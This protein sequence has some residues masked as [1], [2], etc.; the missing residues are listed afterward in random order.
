[1]RKQ[2]L[3]HAL[4]M[5][6]IT[7]SW[8]LT[9]IDLAS[10]VSAKSRELA[11]ALSVWSIAYLLGFLAGQTIA[12]SPGRWRIPYFASAILILAI[13]P[14]GR[15]GAGPLLGLVLASVAMGL[16]SAASTR[17]LFDTVP[18]EAWSR[19]LA[20]VKLVGGTV[21]A[22]A[23]AV[24]VI[25][26]HTGLLGD[27][28]AVYTASAAAVIAAGLSVRRPA[29]PELALDQLDKSFDSLSFGV[30]PPRV[31]GRV[32]VSLGMLFS[33]AVIARLL[34][35]KQY[36]DVLNP[37]AAMIMYA[38]FYSA[39]AI[40]GAR[41]PSPGRIAI[42][43]IGVALIHIVLP[44]ALLGAILELGS[45]LAY[46][47]YAEAGLIM[48]V[49][50]AA[51]AMLGK[52]TRVAAITVLVSSLVVVALILWGAGYDAVIGLLAVAALA[53]QYRRARWS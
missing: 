4:G 48:Y 33:L 17:I 11:I 44:T 25:L 34:S 32:M 30:E 6:G 24:V 21:Y 8:A 42:A 39:G 23:I 16:Y 26:E 52:V 45:S 31:T 7:A 29:V 1:M 51:P 12:R 15:E 46:S 53:A 38:V 20:W 19:V 36:Q 10:G 50:S 27:P 2:I 47:G 5:A 49:L 28:R 40:L 43:G 37:V 18:S 22:G 14:L 13:P 35:L 3:M 41:N 9:E